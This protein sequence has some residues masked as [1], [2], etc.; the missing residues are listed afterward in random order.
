VIRLATL[1]FATLI[2]IVGLF[3][4][5]RVIGAPVAVTSDAVAEASSGANRQA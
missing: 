1:W 5:R 4:V 3:A 2:G